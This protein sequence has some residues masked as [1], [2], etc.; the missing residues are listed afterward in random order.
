MN[1][2]QTEEK[3]TV[4]AC[5]SP[6]VMIATFLIEVFGALWLLYRYKTTLAA[7][8]MIAILLCLGLFQFAEYMV[9]EGALGISSL[10]WARIGYVAITFLPPLG[11]HLGMAIAKRHHKLVLIVSYVAAITFSAFFLFV[12]RGMGG[13][14]C[15]GNYVLFDIAEAAVWPYFFYYYGWLALGTVLA[16]E[17]ARKP[18]IERHAKDALRGLA[19]GYMAFIL[20]T[21]IVNIINPETIA[22]IPSIM[23]GFAVILALVL[24]FWVAPHALERRAAK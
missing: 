17:F 12:E 7:K 20:P 10:D 24:L 2:K 1:K 6:P 14:V 3:G 21:T 13:S 9:C 19:V 5:F 4:L 22:G 18:G 15:L 16:W 11:L 8:L 23:C